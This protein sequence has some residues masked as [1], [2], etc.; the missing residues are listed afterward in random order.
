MRRSPEEFQDCQ[1]VLIDIAKRLKEALRL[2][3]V[4]TG[5]G[6]DYVVEPDVYIGGVI[7]RRERVGAFFYVRPEVAESAREIMVRHGFKPWSLD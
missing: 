6:I 4:F 1:P 3:E 2:E 7:F 5:A